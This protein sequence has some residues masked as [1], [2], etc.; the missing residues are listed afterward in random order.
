VT[1]GAGTR[2]PSTPV[3]TTLAGLASIR[4]TPTTL[5]NLTLQAS[6]PSMAPA[7]FDVNSL[8][9]PPSRLVIVSGNNQTG[10]VGTRLAQPLVI[11]AQDA[12]GN[13]TPGIFLEAA[14]SASTGNA[15]TLSS[16]L[17]QTGTD[18]TASADWTL[19]GRTGATLHTVRVQAQ[20]FGIAPVTFAVVARPGPV[21]N[22][23]ILSGNNQVERFGAVLPEPLVVRATDEF[24]NFADGA[25][26]TWTGSA[27]TTINPA[28]SAVALDGTA[29]TVVTLSP[30]PALAEFEILASANSVEVLFNA[31][32]R[33][34]GIDRIDPPRWLNPVIPGSLPG[35]ITVYGGGFE[36]GMTVVVRNE[37]GMEVE[38]VPTSFTTSE[39]EFD[40][41]QLNTD[42]LGFESATWHVEVSRGENR[43]ATLA[44]PILGFV[45]VPAGTF[46]Q[47]TPGN[48]SN[49]RPFEATIT[50][51]Y[52]VFATEV[53][54]GQWLAAT[55]GVN[56][57]SSTS[58]GN[59]CPVTQVDW[60]STLAYANWLSEQGGL[61]PCYGLT[62]TTCADSISDWADGKTSCTG[63]TFVGLSCPGYR[64]LTES[65]WER[66]A[67]AGTT[68][69]YYWGF[70]TG[71]ATVGLYAWF[72]SNAG[73][74]TRSVGTK[75]PNAYGLY[76]M[77]GNVEEW[78]WDVYATSYP[79]GSATDYI[80][81]TSGSGLGIRGGSFGSSA[82]G[83]RSAS[84]FSF[85][86][87]DRYFFLGV[88]LARTL[89]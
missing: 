10:V 83:L 44:V 85:F 37:D 67:R 88:R 74:R 54:Q 47:G 57:S 69:T 58:C 62:P 34:F 80:G 81:P 42:V 25:Q 66:A 48:T 45:R 17:L 7:V 56:P 5:G 21:T 84:R 79:S 2:D 19:G 27:G 82:S 32:A 9:G 55:G 65:E 29:R 36:P 11:L 60:L 14:A 87:N 77:S 3:T 28:T 64:L 20:A 52:L 72:G 30:D 22:L 49:E 71:T 31:E 86:A 12:L 73:N 15:G 6:A 43:S 63:V 39:I 59:D 4:F 61:A 16:T 75:L 50:R 26:V 68:S 53:T 46:F 76:D 33:G 40:P 35:T 13:P 89:P 38:V 41:T 78:V 51:D 18:G 23:E 8:T 1:T 70:A 24:G